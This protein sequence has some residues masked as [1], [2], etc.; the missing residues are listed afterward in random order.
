MTDAPD[1]IWIDNEMYEHHWHEGSAPD[2]GVYPHVHGEYIRADLATQ[3][4]TIETAPKDGTDILV[5]YNHDADP[6]H[7]SETR[8]TPYAAWAESGDF[9]DGI[10]VCIAAWQP[11]YWEST[12]EY[13]SGYN[14][15]AYWFAHQM[16]EYEYVVNPTH[17]MPLPAP[18]TKEGG[19]T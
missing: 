8:L 12:D 5:Y 6:Y 1:R 10:G 18:P 15:H 14:L 11:S 13:G 4:Q 2:R 19:D 17:W 3:W 7:E 16:G 9:M